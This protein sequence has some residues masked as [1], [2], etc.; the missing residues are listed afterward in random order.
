MSVEQK[1]NAAELQLF[2]DFYERRLAEA[3]SAKD[4]SQEL[5]IAQDILL[6]VIN[7]GLTPTADGGASYVRRGALDWSD[8]ATLQAAKT[9]TGQKRIIGRPPVRGGGGRKEILQGV[10]IIAI[11]VAAIVWFLWPAA[12]DNPATPADDG[13][14]SEMEVIPETADLRQTMPTPLPTLETEL[15][16]DV[17]GA[18]AKTKQLVVPRT[19]DIKG[20]S[21][22]VQP[23]K[24]GVG[25]WPLPESE[26]AVSWVYGTV[27]NYVMGLEA[28]PAN[29]RL[30]ASLRSGDQML[31]RMSTGPTY[32]FILADLVRVAPQTSEVFLQNR[33]GLTL[34]LLSDEAESR[35][36]LRALY[37]P[38]SELGLANP[39]PVK[40]AAPG[41]RVVLADR[42]RLTYLNY[43]IIPVPDTP[44]GYAYLGI[45]FV[46][47]NVGGNASLL[48][49]SLLH[50]L[51]SNGLTYPSVSTAG[52]LSY[53]SLPETLPVRTPLTA[54]LVYAVPETTLREALIWLFALEPT[55]ARAQ[56]TLPPYEGRLTPEVVVKE[57]SLDN[58]ILFLG[59]EVRAALRNLQVGVAE[60]Q[61]QG[62]SLSP[63][64]NYFPWRVA[65]GET[66][67]FILLLTPDGSGRLVIT[68]L[69]QGIEVTY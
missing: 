60:V 58:G 29:K 31:L 36:I 68:L 27:I 63:V 69:E 34:V 37:I 13:S 43:E 10:G 16:A 25:D 50:H 40:Q 38:D 15:L 7:D 48:T 6:A 54:T 5:E 39:E 49:A 44:P 51:E 61:V 12:G 46:L 20:V 17:I 45:N 42:L 3:G 14:Q 35:V 8:P 59:L 64:G 33:P 65:A 28:T 55:G 1:L 24:I 52:A 26:R 62:G 4:D 56:V 2:S 22:V 57:A 47:E 18:G 53:P 41:E 11:A 9:T 30:L 21:F 32:R 23:V 66:D 19:L 67:E